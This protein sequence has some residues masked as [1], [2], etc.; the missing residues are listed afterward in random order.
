ML[1]SSESVMR[2]LFI[3]ILVWT[4]WIE[5]DCSAAESGAPDCAACSE[6]YSAAY[7]D[8]Y[9]P[10]TAL[11]MIRQ[12][13]GF[14]L[15]DGEERRGFGG[16]AGNVLING[17]RPSAKSET[18]SDILGRIP[19]QNVV[20]IDVITGSLAGFDL[21]GQTKIVN[22]ITKKSSEGSTAWKIGT[23]FVLRGRAYAPFGAASYEGR[24]NGIEFNV[25]ISGERGLGAEFGNE[26][27]FD[28]T[29]ALIETRG[30]SEDE[31]GYEFALNLNAGAGLGAGRLQFNSE[32]TFEREITF[33]NSLR[34]PL[35]T[36]ARAF[37]VL[38]E[39]DN[40]VRSFEFGADYET[41]L[42]PA[43]SGKVVGL[44]RRELFPEI[45]RL[46]DPDENDPDVVELSVSNERATNTET[47]GRVIVNYEGVEDHVF[48]VS[49]EGAVNKLQN[50]FS[51]FVD[52][53][54]GPVEE[55]VPNANTQVS[56]RR[57]EFDFQDAWTPGKFVVE[58]NIGFEAS[59]ISQSGDTTARRNFFYI[60]PGL[61]VA[62][63][64]NDR[65]QFLLRAYR[66]VSQLD[67]F[68]FV[69][70]AD[71]EDQD[72]AFGNPD[73]RPESTWIAEATFDKNFSN[74]AALRVTGFHHWVNDVQDL[75]PIG[76]GDETPGNIGDGVRWGARANGSLPLDSIGMK[77]ARLDFEGEWR[78]TRV[79][80]LVT[81]VPRGFSNEQDWLASLEYRQDFRAHGV[82]WGWDLEIGAPEVE[83]GLDEF[84]RQREGPDLDAYVEISRFKDVKLTVS[85]QNVLGAGEKRRREKFVGDRVL[86][87]IEFIELRDRQ[88][89]RTVTIQLS[90]SF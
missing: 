54:S 50:V 87:T 47:I 80:D 59:Q 4:V 66:D 29:S 2:S 77:N 85:L 46:V 72:V 53:G 32:A 60:K 12:V 44:F 67:F 79:T 26:R 33:E 74:G 52:D 42:G 57:F 69:S 88:Y 86:S 10:V 22:V 24:W 13:P 61:S 63:L 19:A 9:Q 11:D 37:E 16:V 43:L 70:A 25:G 8:Q 35:L 39:S 62:Y 58:G 55:D 40:R 45:E 28:A 84:E 65:E 56:E 38:Q 51:L 83:F 30:E 36:P 71:F 78:K 89:A 27:V 82:A 81:G 23:E 21:R 3:A 31:K 75:L 5:P 49:G 17:E 20:R 76:D 64:S 15:D 6:S 1:L 34:R 41:P 7:F 68:D 90:G 48:V 18:V 73:L 14:Q